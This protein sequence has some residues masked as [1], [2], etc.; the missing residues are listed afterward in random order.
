MGFMD[1]TRKV[2][3]EVTLKEAEMRWGPPGAPKKPMRKTAVLE[4]APSNR[5]STKRLFI[6]DWAKPILVEARPPAVLFGENSD[7]SFARW[8]I[9]WPHTREFRFV[10]G[11]VV[12]LR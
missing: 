1:L 7:F 2:R 10:N 9:S 3:G 5:F 4:K 8:A 6:G 12:R 11:T